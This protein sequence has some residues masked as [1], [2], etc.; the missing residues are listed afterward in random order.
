[1]NSISSGLLRTNNIDII[2]ELLKCYEISKKHIQRRLS[3][4]VRGNYCEVVDILL[5]YDSNQR[6]I[7]R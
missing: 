1:M 5:K 4:A 7:N 3:N 2:K 6:T